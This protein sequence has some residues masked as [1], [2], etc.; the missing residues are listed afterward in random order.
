MKAEGITIIGADIAHVPLEDRKRKRIVK[1]KQEKTSEEKTSGKVSA[2][3]AGTY[4]AK[5]TEEMKAS[6][7]KEKVVEVTVSEEKTAT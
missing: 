5:S 6:E 2:S 3:G 4:V 1:I 7:D